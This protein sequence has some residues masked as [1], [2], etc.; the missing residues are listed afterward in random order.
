MAIS[1]YYLMFCNGINNSREEAQASADIISN[2]FNKKVELFHKSSKLSDVV[3]S[4][5]QNEEM[6]KALADKVNDLIKDYHVIVFAHS[7]GVFLINEASRKIEQKN[8]LIIYAFGGIRFVSDPSVSEVKN[9][10]N[11]DDTFPMALATN[12]QEKEEELV[13]IS[14]DSKIGKYTVSKKTEV[15]A[16]TKSPEDMTFSKLIKVMPGIFFTS[17]SIV[18]QPKFISATLQG[19]SQVGEFYVS[20][21]RRIDAHTFSSY[22]PMIKWIAQHDNPMSKGESKEIS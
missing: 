6:I 16:T 12:A 13:Y 15:F 2:A 22:E 7:H 17:M 9:C 1:T 3:P 10:Y 19:M 4:S 21:P 18:T 14:K 20:I 8:K 5:S 11:E